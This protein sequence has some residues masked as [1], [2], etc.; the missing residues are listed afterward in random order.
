MSTPSYAVAGLVLSPNPAFSPRFGI[1]NRTCALSDTERALS[2]GY[3]DGDRERGEG[4]RIRSD[5]Q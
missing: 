3:S 1:S 5:E 2:T 4:A